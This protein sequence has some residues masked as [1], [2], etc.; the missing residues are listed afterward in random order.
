[1]A[2]ANGSGLGDS[3]G[4]AEDP[5]IIGLVTAWLETRKEEF[6]ATG[7]LAIAEAKLA[8]VSLMTMLVLG[9]IAVVFVLTTWGLLIASIA[10]GLVAADVPLWLTLALLAAT[11]ISG[12]WLLYRGAM[13]MRKRFMFIETRKQLTDGRNRAEGGSGKAG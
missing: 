8:A 4:V 6:Q 7:R 12:A 5:G 3:R 13:R 1:M 2:D 10:T 9:A 11:H